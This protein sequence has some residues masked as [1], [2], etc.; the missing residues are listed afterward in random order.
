VRDMSRVSPKEQLAQWMIQ[1]S[2]ATGHGDTMA[3][4]LNELEVQIEE[5]VTVARQDGYSDGLSD[6]YCDA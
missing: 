2:F 6:G 4:L 3:D 5:R 1:N